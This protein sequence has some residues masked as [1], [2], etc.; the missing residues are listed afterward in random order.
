MFQA[1]PDFEGGNI[2][3]YSNIPGISKPAPDLNTS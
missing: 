2:F 1:R 3:H